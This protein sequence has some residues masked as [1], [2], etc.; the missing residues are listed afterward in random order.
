[1]LLLLLLLLLLFLFLLLSLQ[2][3][4][5]VGIMLS[6]DKFAVWKKMNKIRID[7][8]KKSDFDNTDVTAFNSSS[9][10][11]EIKQKKSLGML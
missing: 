2:L 11:T 7:H 9:S 3:F 1:M 10:S 8:M 5:A 4:I 6:I